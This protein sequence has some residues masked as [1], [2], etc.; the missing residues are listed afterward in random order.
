MVRQ[1][2]AGRWISAVCKALLR[3]VEWF[4][5]TAVRCCS[6]DRLHQSPFACPPASIH[7]FQVLF[8]DTILYNIKYA[9]PHATDEE[10]RG[11]VC[12]LAAHLVHL[13]LL[14]NF[15]PAL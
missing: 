5:C 14:H 3:A 11:G 15:Y 8:N 13:G 10:V 1:W 7:S 9:K 6:L 2:V 12:A 4:C